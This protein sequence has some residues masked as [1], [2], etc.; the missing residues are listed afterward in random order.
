[1]P[2][3]DGTGPWGAGPLSGRGLGYCPR[4]ASG[5]GRRFGPAAAAPRTREEEQSVLQEQLE[6]IQ[7]SLTEISKALGERGK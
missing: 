5:W 2:R 3:G 6:A 1:M 7:I 4:W